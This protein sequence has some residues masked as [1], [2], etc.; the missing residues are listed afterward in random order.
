MP[1]SLIETRYRTPR[2]RPPGAKSAEFGVA[3]STAPANRR[4]PLPAVV[5]C[6]HI[7]NHFRV[8]HQCQVAPQR[9]AAAAQALVG[10]VALVGAGIAGMHAVAGEERG[11]LVVLVLG[12]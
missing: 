1:G 7:F 6:E 10:I 8:L 3:G 5:R 12:E 9:V 11:H 2:F 4:P